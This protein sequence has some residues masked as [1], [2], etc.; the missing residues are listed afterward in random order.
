VF[1]GAQVSLLESG[2]SSVPTKKRVPSQDV[3]LVTSPLVQ[4]QARYW[5]DDALDESNMYVSAVAV[6]GPFV[7]NSTLVID[8]AG[9]ALT[10]NGKAISGDGIEI[11]GLLHATLSKEG[12]VVAELPLGVTLKV[13]RK[14]RHLNTHITMPCGVTVQDGLC[15]NFNG[16]SADDVTGLVAKRRAL[17]VDPASSFFNGYRVAPP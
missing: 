11:P 5:Q 12:D 1:D 8:Q 9:D 3:W 6:G 10:W 17:H 14:S 4:I 7:A 16:Y 2:A 13:E 15:G